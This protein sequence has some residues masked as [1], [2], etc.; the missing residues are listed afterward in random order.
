MS[1]NVFDEKSLT[2]DEDPKKVARARATADRIREAVPVRGDMRMMEY[3]AGTGQVAQGLQDHV[4]HVVLADSSSGMLEKL[5]DKLDA[6]VFRDAEVRDLDLGRDPLPDDRFDLIVTV[7]AMHHIVDLPPVLSAFEQLLAPGGVL[8]VVDLEEEDGTFHKYEF[9]G[10]QGFA[11]DK[12]TSLL[13]DAGLGDVEF[14]DC[15]AVEKPHGTYPMFLAI[16]QR[17]V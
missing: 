3:G 12:M 14:R 7:M 8:C 9:D 17:P 6:G 5:Q 4:G 16:A 1:D 15:G 11:R 2:W 13:T 10:H